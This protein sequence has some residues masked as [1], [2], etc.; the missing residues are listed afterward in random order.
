VIGVVWATWH[1]PGWYLHLG[2]TVAWTAGM[3]VTTVALRVLVVWLCVRS[4]GSVFAAVLVHV[5]VNLCLA[6]P[7]QYDPVLVAP[8][9]VVLAVLVAV[10]LRRGT[11]DGASRGQ[12][13]TTRLVG[14]QQRVVEEERGEVE[15]GG[16]PEGSHRQPGPR[17]GKVDWSAGEQVGQESGDNCAEGPSRSPSWT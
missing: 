15:Q 1:L 11:G 10:A 16:E 8:L 2:H 13:G 17:R 14:H 6:F 12:G 3:W 4:G 7:A 5:T 9:V